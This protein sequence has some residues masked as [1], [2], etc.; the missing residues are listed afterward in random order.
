[1]ISYKSFMMCLFIL[2][3]VLTSACQSVPVSVAPSPAVESRPEPTATPTSFTYGVTVLDDENNPIPDAEVTIEIEGKSPLTE[4]SDDIGYARMAVPTT[5]AERPGRLIVRANGFEVETRNIDIYQDQLPKTIILTP[6]VDGNTTGFCPNN[7][8]F[9]TGFKPAKDNETLVVVSNFA[10]TD[11]KDPRNVTFDLIE[12]MRSELETHETIRVERLNC[13]IK[14]ENGSETAMQIGKRADVDASILIWGTYV[15]PPD[16]EVRIYFDIVKQKE[17][18][19][20]EGFDQPFGPKSIPDMFDFKASLGTQ[21]GQVVAFAAGLALFNSSEYLAAESFFNTAIAVADQQIASDF[22]L[23]VYFYR[24]TNYQRLGRA[25]EAEKDLAVLL[26][27]IDSDS[28]LYIS[29]LNNIGGVYSAL[30]DKEQALEFYNQALPLRREVGDKA[31]EA[32]TLNNIG[33]VYDD[34]GDKDQALELFNQALP[35]RREVGDKAGEAST[36]TNIGGVYDDLG[37]KDQALEL[38]NQAL[39]LRREVGDKAGEANTLTN[40]GGVYAALGDKDQALELFNQALPLRRE[41]GDKAGEA[42]TLN[43]IGWIYDALGDKEQALDFYNQALLLFREVGDKA[44]EA[45][46]INNIGVVYDGLGDK[47]HALELFNQALPLR[48]E[49]GDKAGEAS[50]L[51]NIGAVYSALGDKDHALEYYNQALP[52]SREVGD[53]A[54]E[55]TILNNIGGVY[56][57]L[58]DKE[59][60]LEFYNQA[61]PL[62][63]EVGDRWGESTTRYNMGIV[64]AQLGELQK[65]EE[66]L[67]IVVELEEAIGH[68][69]LE[70]DRQVLE[71]IRSMIAEQEGN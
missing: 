67:K 57:A 39:P 6:Q 19:L 30:G 18:Y 28:D 44:G 48:R 60:A 8:T 29:T 53:K 5:H 1:M 17:T 23:A 70:S 26:S 15:A 45:N 9:S 64:Y 68:P 4:Q 22:S 35:L 69:D 66:Q 10:D 36:L 43:N 33:G 41:V 51:S 25:L 27:I 56:D 40:I 47:D 24:G 11:G 21:A 55:A 54:G 49:V 63:R 58:G 14:Q 32:T 59:E 50:T 52:L 61:L 71:Q 62:R 20:G 31:G 2:L 65:A 46:T 38:F 12:K 37:D 34:L 16:P 3:T 13:A 7:L 42:S